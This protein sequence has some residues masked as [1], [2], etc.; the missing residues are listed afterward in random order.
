MR[1]I[2]DNFYISNYEEVRDQLEALG[3]VPCEKTIKTMDYVLKQLEK[4]NQI[5]RFD[6]FFE[7]LDQDIFNNIKITEGMVG[8]LKD[9]YGFQCASVQKEGLPRKDGRPYKVIAT[10]IRVVDDKP[11]LV[12]KDHLVNDKDIVLFY[13][14]AYATPDYNIFWIAKMLGETDVS[15]LKNI[16]YARYAPLLRVMNE[17]EKAQM[18][19]AVDEIVQGELAI[20]VGDDTFE[21]LLNKEQSPVI[22][23]TDV[24]QSDK[25]QYLSHLYQDF[26]KRFSMEYGFPISGVEKM[27]QQNNDEINGD[28]AYSWLTPIDMLNQAKEGIQRC[29]KLWPDLEID[30][31]FGTLHELMYLKF[32]QDITKDNPDMNVSIEDNQNLEDLK[33]ME[34]YSK[35]E[36]PEE[37]PEDDPEDPEEP[38]KEEEDPKEEDPKEEDPEKKEEEDE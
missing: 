38:E 6:N 21:E 1:N 11:E 31:H 32:A 12:V 37:A 22:N 29:K 25:I 27:A 34:M 7:G 3:W 18:E 14:T 2:N 9:E 33:P 28:V 4:V 26:I 30:A 19:A 20:M 5:V 23:I 8:I 24:S 13:N 17:K 10:Y 35:N 15:I 16:I 36:N